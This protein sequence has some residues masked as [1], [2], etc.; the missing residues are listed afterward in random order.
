MGVLLLEI[1]SEIFA[2]EVIGCLGFT[3]KPSGV[4][5]GGGVDDKRLFTVDSC[6]LG[7]GYIGV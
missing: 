6:W 1:H 7:D 5:M 4:Q 2:D 3:P